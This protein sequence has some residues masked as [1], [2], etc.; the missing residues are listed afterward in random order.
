LDQPYK[1]S[2]DDTELDVMVAL[3]HNL[4]DEAVCIH[5]TFLDWETDG[6][7]DVATPKKFSPAIYR[8][9]MTGSAIQLRPYSNGLLGIAEGIETAEAVYQATRIPT[10]AAGS[11]GNMGSFI[12]PD[13]VTKLCI[14]ADNDEHGVGIKAAEKLK[15]RLKGRNIRVKIFVPPVVGED[16]LDVLVKHG[17]E[18]MF[19]ILKASASK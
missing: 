7:A 17:E 16:W 1:D 8:G 5:Q 18:E 12:P 4:A 13:D 3:F 14:W 19:K 11:A 9:A 15:E 6:K 2:D 10:W